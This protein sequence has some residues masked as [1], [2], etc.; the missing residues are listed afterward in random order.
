MQPSTT[1][2][3]RTIILVLVV[4]L[5]LFLVVK[6]LNTPRR[7]SSEK[8]LANKEEKALERK[9]AQALHRADSLQAVADSLV[10]SSRLVYALGVDAGK[11]AAALRLETHSKPS[12]HV[13]APTPASTKHLQQYFDEY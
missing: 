2:A 7:D 1:N 13:Q 12:P 8:P 4:L 10:S 11:E 6:C 3:R 5:L 9:M